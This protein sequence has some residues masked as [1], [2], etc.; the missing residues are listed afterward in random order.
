MQASQRRCLLLVVAR[1]ADHGRVNVNG[2]FHRFDPGGVAT[3]FLP[4]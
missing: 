3:S 1:I 2:W 4:P